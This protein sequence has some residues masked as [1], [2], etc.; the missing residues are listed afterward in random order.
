MEREA[1]NKKGMDSAL[2]EPALEAPAGPSLQDDLPT[3][4]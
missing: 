3:E 2:A 1:G 4:Y